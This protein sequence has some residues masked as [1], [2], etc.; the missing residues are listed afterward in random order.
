L[1][2]G[3]ALLGLVACETTSGAGFAAGLGDSDAKLM[4]EATQRALESSRVGESENWRGE[5][6]RIRGTVTPIRTIEETGK[7]PC[8][9]Y[10]RSLTVAGRTT[11]E[12]ATACRG[13]KAGWKTIDRVYL[14]TRPYRY[15]YDPHYDHYWPHRRRYSLGYGPH[16]HGRHGIRFGIGFHN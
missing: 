15:G 1:A 11:F 6:D 4:A 9:D 2:V 14:G 7:R 5:S 10:Q 8:R 16:F 3:T 12:F 13:E